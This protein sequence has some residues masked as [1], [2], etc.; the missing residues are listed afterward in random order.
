MKLY[1]VII[2]F[3]AF[4][5]A[6]VRS[7]GQFFDFSGSRAQ[8]LANASSGLTGCWSVFGN[9]AG[10]AGSANPE[11]AIAFQ[12]RFL[13]PEL[14]DRIGLFILP[15]QSTVFAFSF[16]QFG[17]ISFRHEKYG[18][19]Y[20]RH[21]SPKIR[22]G[23]QFNYFRFYLPEANRSAGS[24]GLE[25]GV[26]FAVNSKLNLGLHVA[27]PYQTTVKTYAGT[28]NYPS[29]VNM[30]FRY[31]LSEACFWVSEIEND[32]DRYFRV[33]TGLEYSMLE[34]LF[35][36]IGVATNPYKLSSGIGFRL[37]KLTVDL[38]NSF[39]ANLGNSP[40]VSITYSLGR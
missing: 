25:L 32:F 23:L 27:N 3:F 16:Y 28:Y 22:F 8:S 30:G 13:V 9:Q 2:L 34:K 39:H 26:Q 21:I 19:A 33:R 40:S 17:Q 24:A 5:L 10:L 1:P 11:I 14:S 6:A 37:R 15:L 29:R 4:T 20:A 12:D 38:G 7:S 36:R 18:L 35:L 31:F